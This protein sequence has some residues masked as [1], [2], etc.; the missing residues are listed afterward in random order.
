MADFKKTLEALGQ[1]NISLDGLSKQLDTLLKQS[2]EYAPRLLSL[3]DEAESDKTIT[4]DDHT[5]LKRKINQFRREN[6]GQT[7]SGSATE[8]DATVF[9][10]APAQETYEKTTVTTSEDDKTAIME[11]TNAQQ[12]EDSELEQIA[13]E[14]RD[15]SQTTDT[16]TGTGV[17]FDLMTDSGVS[18]TGTSGPA[19]TAWSDPSQD[20]T[21][22]AA[23][24]TVGSVIKQRFKLLSV[25]GIG[26]MGKVYKGIDL[27]KQ[28]ARDKNPYVA[29]KLLNE[30][31]KTHPEAFISLQRE[32]SRQQ[33]L[34][35]PNIAT[36]YDFDRVGG[37]GTPVYIT[38][39]MMEGMELKDY[40][41][42]EVRKRGG[43]PFDEAFDI[44]KQ[45]GAALSYAH[46]RR[47][48][49]SDFKPGNAFMCT[50][51]TVKTLDFGIARAVKNPVTGEAEKT[52]F[53]PGK[54]GALTPAYASL[55]MLEG[56]E[57]DTRDDIYALGCVAYELLTTKHPFNKLPANAARENSLVPATVKGLKKKQNKALRK[58]VAFTRADRCQTVDEFIEDLEARYIWYKH[59][60]TVA[61]ILAVVIGLGSIAP[62][63]NYFEKEKIN[64]LIA[65]FNSGNPQT[66]STR[67]S[68]LDQLETSHQL[69]ITTEAKVAIQK[70]YSD[71]ISRLTD[72][73]SQDYNFPKAGKE[74]EKIGA[75]YPGSSFFTEQKEIVAFNKKQKLSDLYT[76]FTDVLKDPNLI[77]DSQT[78]LDTIR[79]RIDPQHPLLKDPRPSNAYRLLAED[80]F[81]QG[82]FDQALALV[83]SGLE[84]A[85]DDLRLQD[86]QTRIEKAMRIAELQ[87]DL[88]DVQP[89]LLSLSDYKNSEENIIA[90][91]ALNPSDIILSGFT[92]SVRQLAETEIGTL[93]ESGSRS[94][95]ETL[96]AEYGNL[97]SALQLGTELSRIKLAHLSGAAL[98]EAI[99]SI[100]ATNKTRIEELLSD[101]KISDPKWESELL[102]NVQELESL[103]KEDPRI[104]SEL[105]PIRNSIASLYVDEANKILAAERFDAANDIIQQGARYAPD[106]AQIESTKSAISDAR[107]EYERQLRVA[108][109]K[110]DFKIQAAANKVTEANTI[111]EQLKAD[112]PA[113]DPYITSEAP[114]LLSDSYAALAKSQ[115][116]AKNYPTALK[117]A[118]AGMKLNPKNAL[119]KAA[120]G[121][122]LVEAYTIELAEQFDKSIS[123]DVNDIRRKFGEMEIA[124]PSRYSDFRRESMAKLTDRI[125]AI[126]DSDVNT[127]ATLAQN[128]AAIFPGTELEQLKDSLKPQPWPDAAVASAAITAGEFSRAQELQQAAAA[129]FTGHPDYVAFSENLSTKM[130]E[131]K[132][133][134]DSYVAARD[135]AGTDYKKLNASI[136]LL[137]Q[138]Q[139][140]WVDN[141]DY[142]EAETDLKALLAANKPAPK[143][144]KKEETDFSETTVAT[145][146]PGAT[147]TGTG[148]ATAAAVEWKPVSSGREC[149]KRLAGY[150]KRAKAIC[151]DLVNDSWRGPLM[152]VVPGGDNFANGF[153]I[154]KYE[155]SVND[156]SKYC[157]LSGRCQPIKE[158]EKQNNPMTGI[159]LQQ[160]Q[161]YAQ[162][163]SERTGKTY[164]IP[165]VEEWQ[166]A[167]DAGGKQPK[168]DFNCRLA[169]GEKVIKG[170]GIVSVK[171]GKSNGWGLK[172]YVGN[173]QEWVT[174]SSGNMARGGAFSD[175]H[176]KCNLSLER[177]H[178]GNADDATGFRLILEDVG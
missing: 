15:A 45:L 145:A 61:A 3:L 12:V 176:A 10:Q 142:Q 102:A 57:P 161:E 101:S 44:I 76:Q 155:I 111:L 64:G 1:G 21:D 100:V 174:G 154:G 123:F 170:T 85:P 63:L 27:L 173:V 30:D 75:I 80:A 81:Q 37:P 28:E 162:W 113:D 136:R 168:K 22:D 9:E 132:A 167:A 128:A 52:L 130:G 34:A 31:F 127:A 13:S 94:D 138:A 67:L 29:I 92:A 91:A 164:R 39:E 26:G 114:S 171:S 148:T 178:D 133:A 112:L 131:A 159:S 105:T 120:R 59:P 79:D 116:E 129:E 146:E 135:E 71:N 74:L 153:A 18:T 60:L 24:L 65:D 104:T 47:L 169:V 40:I 46:E 137:K 143:V 38:M 66:I 119:L 165:S 96:A 82:N 156:Y 20:P 151:Y 98:A 149:E 93:L 160:A 118:D 73:N 32:S 110:E 141:P 51:G 6:A 125:N 11:D 41:R 50:N 124:D 117:L 36:V 56:E 19:E 126:K 53:D 106:N 121:E 89:Q 77:N 157:A 86:T 4:S 95:A 83:A 43:L 72:T 42:K 16:G 7:E 166:Y 134:Y 158:K 163:L 152:V 172:N 23:G 99:Q 175:P 144:I 17:D 8:S 108:S 87:Q 68:E 55:E 90:L 58:A 103:S 115:F 69:T 177:P 97:L 139:A 150:G 35:H 33:K 48:V 88:S 14:V 62:V 107:L 109:L 49:H 70:Y 25:L 147:G 2:P 140:M 84:T 122:F 78:I 5:T 54:L